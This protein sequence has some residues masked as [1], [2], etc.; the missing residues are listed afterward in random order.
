MTSHKGSQKTA[1]LLH[2][3]KHMALKKQSH[4]TS[5]LEVLVDLL[6]P[7]EGGGWGRWGG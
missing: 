5:K 3:A 6:C 1:E 2:I 7:G 4:P